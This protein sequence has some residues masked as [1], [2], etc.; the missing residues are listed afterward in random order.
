[1]K[2]NCII[3]N[4]V[5]K[6]ELKNYLKQYK[7][8]FLLTS[9]EETYPRLVS[10]PNYIERN[11]LVLKKLYLEIIQ[12]FK[13]NFTKFNKLKFNKDLDFFDFSIIEE[14][15]PF[16]S[17]A[18]QN[19]LIFISLNILFKKY[20]INEVSYNAHNKYIEIALKENEINLKIKKLIVSNKYSRNNIINNYKVIFKNFILSLNEIFFNI[21]LIFFLRKKKTTIKKNIENWIFTQF[22]HLDLKKNFIP[23][24]WTNFKYLLNLDKILWCFMYVKSDQF[25]TTKDLSNYLKKNKNKNILFLHS[26]GSVQLIIKALIIYFKILI[27]FLIKQKNKSF[28]FRNNNFYELFQEDL[29][30]SY[31]GV[32]AIKNIFNFLLIDKLYKKFELKKIFYLFENQPHEKYLNYTFNRKTKCIGFA[33]SSIRFWHLSYYNFKKSKKNK[34]YDPNFIC[35]SKNKFNFTEHMNFNSKIIDIEPIRFLYSKNH[36]EKRAIRKRKILIIGDIL[37]ENTER[38]LSITHKTDLNL[39]NDVYFKK[40]IASDTKLKIR[41]NIKNFDKDI[42]NSLEMFDIYICGSSTTAGIIPYNSNKK[43]LFFNDPYILNLNPINNLEN[44]YKFTN[45]T[46]LFEKIRINRY[47]KKLNNSKITLKKWKKFIKELNTKYK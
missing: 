25:K 13:K 42:Q 15:N 24:Y 2:N 38:M 20:K 33:H 18:I 29:I 32:D 26:L 8:V 41:K 11:R 31:V 5:S 7:F 45:S 16:K 14:K 40:H 19:C 21:K 36:I 27:G 9:Y 43:I 17:N 12:Q 44:E 30:K 10:I 47:K 22:A 37:K 23:S 1:M 28:Y 6:N 46:E 39:K 4:S 35:L 34:I 3:L